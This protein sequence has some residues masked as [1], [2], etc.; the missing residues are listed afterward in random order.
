MN[1]IISTCERTGSNK[2]DFESLARKFDFDYIENFP[3]GQGFGAEEMKNIIKDSVVC[4]V[5]DDSIDSDVFKA[6]TN[7]K[8]IIKWGSGTDQI[9]IDAAKEKGIEIINTP[10]ILGKYVAEF[11]IGLI[12]NSLRQITINNT[13]MKKGIWHKSSGISL[14]KK[15]VGFYGYGD[16]ARSLTK[17][18]KPFDCQIIYSDINDFKLD[19]A[20]YRDFKSLISETEI[21]IISAPL[22]EKTK[23]VINKDSLPNLKRFI[24]FLNASSLGSSSS[25]VSN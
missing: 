3:N 24:N 12:I 23:G 25:S 17:L 6:S 14:Y 4:I 18:L 15:V 1:K 20:K 2:K 8:Y 19:D 22:T 5:G 11:L 13:K 16:I 10:N 9:D 21:L 7:L